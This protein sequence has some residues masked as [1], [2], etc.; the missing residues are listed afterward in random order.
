MTRIAADGRRSFSVLS[1]MIRR[2]PRH[3][4]SINPYIATNANKL[5]PYKQ[6]KTDLDV[7]VRS[8]AV[9]RLRAC[10]KSSFLKPAERAKHKA[11]GGAEGGTPGQNWSAIKPVKRAAAFLA[12]AHSVG[13]GVSTIVLLGF[14][15]QALC[16]RAAPQAQIGAFKTRSKPHSRLDSLELVRML[17]RWRLSCSEGPRSPCRVRARE[18]EP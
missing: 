14:T 16:C 15:P 13:F 12:V 7:R 9:Q 11:R 17:M 10:F 4:R 2:Y 18:Q 1:A 5:T 8:L 6:L 3:P